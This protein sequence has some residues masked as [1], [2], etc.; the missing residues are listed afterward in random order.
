[1]KKIRLIIL[2]LIVAV[3]LSAQQFY[4]LDGTVENRDSR[5][6]IPDATLSLRGTNIGIFSN[7]NGQFKLCDIPSG[8]YEL[9]ISAIGY[10]SDTIVVDINKDL[11]LQI[12]LTQNTISL[13]EVV[14]QEN[15]QRGAKTTISMQSLDNSTPSL[16]S[17]SGNTNFSKLLTNVAGVSTID[18]G[19]NVSKPVIRGMAFNRVAVVNRGITIQNQQ[20]G[21][22]HGLDINSFDVYSATVYRGAN[23]LIFGS[24]AVAGAIE[25][26]GFPSSQKDTFF[27][28]EVNSWASSNND[29]L[30]GAALVERN[31]KSNY[32]KVTGS[33]QSYADYRVPT[34]NFD[35]LYYNLPIEG[36]RLKNTAGR[37]NKLSASYGIWGHRVK[38]MFYVANDYTKNGFFA[39][40]HG[41]PDPDNLKKDDSYRNIAYPYA[42]ANHLTF[43][44]NTELDLGI[45]RILVNTG[46]QDDHRQ[47]M[48]YFHTHYTNVT[49]PPTKDPNLELDFRLHTYSMNARLELKGTEQWRNTV[50]LATEWQQN[51]IEGYDFFL[52][53]YNQIAGGAYA[54]T[55]YIQSEKWSY[56]AGL[57]YDLAHTAITGYYDK[58]L[59]A[60]LAYR[61]YTQSEIDEY[62]WRAYDTDKHFGSWSGAIG[63]VYKP[64]RNQEWYA[65][66]GK[67]FRYPTAV[68]MGANGIHHG[69][70]RHEVGNPNLKPENGY[71][72]D[73]GYKFY[74]N[75]NKLGITIMPFINYFTNYIYLQPSKEY[76]I[77]PHGGQKYIY[78]QNKALYAGAEYDFFMIFD[79]GS[80]DSW[81]LSSK[82]EYVYNRNLDTHYALP[83]TPPLALRNAVEYK[84]TNNNSRFRSIRASVSHRL[85][86]K[87]EHIAQAEDKTDGTNLFSASV[88]FDY[89]FNLTSSTV[90]QI[91]LRADNIFDTRYFN[92]LSY[93]R[94]L[95]IPEP[96]RNIQLFVRVPFSLVK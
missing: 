71:T 15:L 85:Y 56:N 63:T 9:I 87:Q 17:Q 59:A 41:F 93:Y 70:F 38:T 77:L 8:K 6:L 82:G 89:K 78:T 74:R 2:L 51:R 26:K 36:K 37:E 79:S 57:R 34:D 68:E 32:F 58:I 19:A 13:N 67:S 10:Q 53:R 73:F 5:R 20:W 27:R 84:H 18:V 14:I 65:T 80:Q 50:G 22:D 7:E 16:I 69:A 44:N 31:S 28:G 21:V 29:A 12:K 1:M 86:A 90:I 3:Q 4:S 35:Y 92:H 47:E 30:G 46:F 60:D 76:S 94:K 72:L 64:T 23:S 61:N 45:G 43:I 96:G 62:A 83:F 55:T 66:L 54:T 95:N 39:G 33:Y 88:G 49:Q 48:S 52:P 91:D 42:T 11:F 75:D 40:A 81:K 25:I 24:D